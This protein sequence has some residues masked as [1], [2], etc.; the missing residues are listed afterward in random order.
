MKRPATFEFSIGFTLNRLAM[1]MRRRLTRSLE[2]Y[3]L[4][5]ERWQILAAVVDA[6][7]HTLSQSEIAHLTLKDR[8]AVSRMIDKM[9]A[10]GWIEREPD[11]EHGRIQRIGATPTALDQFDDIRT[12]LVDG[13]AVVT[14][15]LTRGDRAEM[16]RIAEHLIG[17]LDASDADDYE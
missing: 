8:Y 2:P 16:L 17:V 9:A 4:N 3:G 7:P 13:F 5:P 15:N 1:L 12:A 11:P 10:D 14:E 6:H